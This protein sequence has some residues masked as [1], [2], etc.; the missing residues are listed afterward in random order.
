MEI[1]IVQHSKD[2]SHNRKF[3]SALKFIRNSHNM[4]KPFSSLHLL[5]IIVT[6]LSTFR[7]ITDQKRI[8]FLNSKGCHQMF[9]N[10]FLFFK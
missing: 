9:E 1:R 5:N 6:F 2:V 4:I 3:A 7:L 8:I 10:F